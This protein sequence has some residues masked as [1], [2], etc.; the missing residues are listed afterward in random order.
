MLRQDNK[1][2]I[3]ITIDNQVHKDFTELMS[4]QFPESSLSSFI[5]NV[6]IE[7]IKDLKEF[8]EFAENLKKNLNASE[9]M[10]ATN[11]KKEEGQN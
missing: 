7:G 8:E 6:L 5:N 2:R 9:F 1:K 10:E 11:K 3:N 4:K